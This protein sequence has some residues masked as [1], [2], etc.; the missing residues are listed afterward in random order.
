MNRKYALLSCLLLLTAGCLGKPSYLESLYGDKIPP[1]L[2]PCLSEAG[3]SDPKFYDCVVKLAEDSKNSSLCGRVFPVMDENIMGSK[4]DS[5]I[6]Q[7]ESNGKDSN[8]CAR[9]SQES[10]KEYCRAVAELSADRCLSLNETQSECR[11]KTENVDFENFGLRTVFTCEAPSK[12]KCLLDVAI[13]SRNET[14]CGMIQ[15]VCD[16]RSNSDCRKNFDECYSQ[17]GERTGN[18]SLCRNLGI[19]FS[20]GEFAAYNPEKSMNECVL[21]VF[22][23][24][25]KLSRCLRLSGRQKGEC[26]SEYAVSTKDPSQCSKIGEELRGAVTFPVSQEDYVKPNSDWGTYAI[27][28]THDECLTN[29]AVNLKDPSLCEG[30]FFVDKGSVICFFEF[31]VLMN[32]SAFCDRISLEEVKNS[33]KSQVGS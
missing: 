24:P 16:V 20:N 32:N 5:C 1:Q 22:D 12:V 15:G 30:E 25:D 26:I 11:L 13:A 19:P 17:V 29:L 33:C 3:D 8:F 23:S 10:L 4:R 21:R 14:P 2:R 9:L 27:S 7:V 18:S 31:A 6:F 28:K